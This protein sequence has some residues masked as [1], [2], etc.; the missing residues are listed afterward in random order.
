VGASTRNRSS[1][2]LVT[3]GSISIPPRALQIMVYTTR[4]IA[5]SMFAVQS[6]CRSA[7]ADGPSTMNFE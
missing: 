5:T 3:V 1:P 6:R 7:R 2:V 4:P